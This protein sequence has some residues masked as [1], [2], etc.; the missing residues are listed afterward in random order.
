MP[1]FETKI[2]HPAGFG[3]RPKGGFFKLINIL[4]PSGLVASDTTFS[5]RTTTCRRFLAIF[6]PPH[7]HPPPTN[8]LKHDRAGAGG[9][10]R[11]DLFLKGKF[12]RLSNVLPKSIRGSE[13]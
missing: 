4:G 5:R 2:T 10:L 3:G 9:F 8:P 7:H 12:G 6:D 11:T 1:S 13:M